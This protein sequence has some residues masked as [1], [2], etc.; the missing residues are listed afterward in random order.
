MLPSSLGH[1]SVIHSGIS[2]TDDVF[3]SMLT[4][5]TH[6][7]DSPYGSD[8]DTRKALAVDNSQ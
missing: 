4:P 7:Y 5:H 6:E 2:H 1:L 8:P 3:Y